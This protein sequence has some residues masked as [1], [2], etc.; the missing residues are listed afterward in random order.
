MVDR[1]KKG[2]Q[3]S[4]NVKLYQ[5]TNALFAYIRSNLWS[6]LKSQDDYWP[7]SRYLFTRGTLPKPPWWLWYWR[8][9]TQP[10]RFF[11]IFQILK[12]IHLDISSTTE[13]L[14]IS[15][16]LKIFKRTPLHFGQ[17]SSRY[18]RRRLV[19]DSD[20]KDHFQLFQTLN[21]E[22]LKITVLFKT[23]KP[24]GHQSTNW[25]FFWTLIPAIEAF[26]S[27]EERSSISCLVLD[28]SAI[29]QTLYNTLGTTSPL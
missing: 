5:W 15:Q 9:S 14:K 28:S 18:N 3:G 27:L 10:Y 6:S 22:I 1:L 26:T 11:N 20:L 12:I 7:M 8:G 16:V 13:L 29:S 17:V 4:Q 21:Y 2:V 23:L 25:I 24:V 19:V